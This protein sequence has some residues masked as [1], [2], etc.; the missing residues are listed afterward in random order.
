MN[1][2]VNNWQWGQHAT[3]V[4]TSLVSASPGRDRNAIIG[5]YRSYNFVVR[6]YLAGNLPI[7]RSPPV[8][9][10]NLYENRAASS[11][12]I[13]VASGPTAYPALDAVAANTT[14]TN[15][16]MRVLSR[17]TLDAAN[18]SQGPTWE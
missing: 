3:A 11:N 8:Y 13:G 18:R 5:P 16:A 17:L 6:D 4:P 15:E 1:N 7:S 10:G 14:N 2:N 9:R 12:L